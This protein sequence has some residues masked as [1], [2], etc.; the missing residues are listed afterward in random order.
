LAAFY[1]DHDIAAETVSGLRQLGHQ[2]TATRALR[3]E[4][5]SDARQLWTAAVNGWILITHDANDYR[6]VHEAWYLWGVGQPHAGIVEIP[7][8]NGLLRQW[9]P[10]NAARE[11]ATF[12]D[13][14]PSIANQLYVWERRPAGEWSHHPRTRRAR[15]PRKRRGWH[16]RYRVRADI[17][18][19]FLWYRSTL[20][21]G[22]FDRL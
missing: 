12:V 10:A 21:L 17:I 1:A 4:R 19:A 11:L 14:H 2:V 9:T 5:A 3:Q 13:Q 22:S 18:G 15:V 20:F 7:H 8:W 16:R 6:L